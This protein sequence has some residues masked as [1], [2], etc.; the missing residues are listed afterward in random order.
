MIK[1]PLSRYTRYQGAIVRDNHILLIMQHVFPPGQERRIV[2]LFPGGQIEPGETEEQCVQREMK[3][4]TNLDVIVISLLV[5]EM[6]TPEDPAYAVLKN[7]KTYYCEPVKGEASPGIEPEYRPEAD[8]TGSHNPLISRVK[9]F[10]LRDESTWDSA[11]VNDP[12]IYLP[13]QRL[14]KKL[15]YLP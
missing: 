12:I 15:G 9:W 13:L 7:Y 14:R 8:P 4:E 5:D 2:W 1:K 6:Y 3:E 10:D 11:L